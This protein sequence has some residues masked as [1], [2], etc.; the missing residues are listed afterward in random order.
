MSEASQ[1][2]KPKVLGLE[3]PPGVACICSVPMLRRILWM[4][5]VS[6]QCV[7]EPLYLFLQKY[8]LLPESITSPGKP[9]ACHWVSP[10]QLCKEMPCETQNPL[11]VL[12]LWVDEYLRLTHEPVGW[13]LRRDEHRIYRHGRQKRCGM[14]WSVVYFMQRGFLC[15]MC[16][17]SAHAC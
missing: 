14:I 17:N 13:V 5:G 1:I 8:R 11:P 9:E 2:V 10:S 7:C 3:D 12:I 6:E 15:C 4:D 16:F